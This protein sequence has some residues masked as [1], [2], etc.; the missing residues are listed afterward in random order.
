MKLL[1]FVES[2]EELLYEVVTWVVLLPKTLLRV[3]FNPGWIRGYVHAEYKKKPEERF[4]E[5]LS[6]FLF[7]FLLWVIPFTLSAI[8]QSGN[9]TELQISLG[10]LSSQI[11]WTVS[12]I[13]GPLIYAVGI[14]IVRREKIGKDT[15]RKPFYMQA[16][17]FSPALSAI[18]FAAISAKPNFLIGSWVIN[19]FAYTLL[20]SLIWL[21]MVEQKVISSELNLSQLKT[22]AFNLIF[23]FIAAF[24]FGVGIKWLGSL[25]GLA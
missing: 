22:F 25:S 18:W 23:F 13:I 3:V 19:P 1:G 16:M 4:R 14:L 15:F 7:W 10:N 8:N 11:M 9:Q 21:L 24:L 6:P 17:C 2:A 5:Y 20:I 12:N